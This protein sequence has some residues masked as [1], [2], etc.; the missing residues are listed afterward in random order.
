MCHFSPYVANF[1]L[2]KPGKKKTLVSRPTSQ[3]QRKL[4]GNLSN[5]VVAFIIGGCS[6]YS[7]SSHVWCQDVKIHQKVYPPASASSLG[8]WWW[9]RRQWWWWRRWGSMQRVVV[10][11]WLCSVNAFHQS[12]LASKT[13]TVNHSMMMMMVSS[14]LFGLSPPDLVPGNK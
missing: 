12:P 14:G 7:W 13:L 1:E 6:K 4:V 11:S 8:G 10:G 9:W 5:I 2:C 3:S